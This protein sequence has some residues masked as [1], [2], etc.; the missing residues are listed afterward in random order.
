MWGSTPIPRP[1]RAAAGFSSLLF[2]FLAA[3]CETFAGLELEEK[4]DALQSGTLHPRNSPT[5]S[6]K[7]LSTLQSNALSEMNGSRRL[8]QPAP[9]LR[10]PSAAGFYNPIPTSAR[11][12]SR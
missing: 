7:T 1:R 12:L 2:F 9:L 6:T 3:R 5:R 11:Q 10:P 4:L 8:A